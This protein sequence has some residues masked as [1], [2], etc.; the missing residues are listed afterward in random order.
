MKKKI[1]RTAEMTALTYKSLWIKAHNK[2]DWKVDTSSMDEY[3]RYVKTYTFTDGFQ[4]IEVNEPSYEKV[5]IDYEVRGV[6]FHEV[7]EVKLFR[8]EIWTTESAS[9]I[10]YEKF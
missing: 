5:A 2:A 4:L 7:K 3:G 8:T 9:E 6:K 10:F 1:E